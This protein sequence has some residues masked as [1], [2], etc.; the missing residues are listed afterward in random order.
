[1][2]DDSAEEAL[3]RS[4]T[5]GLTRQKV[6]LAAAFAGLVPE[7]APL[8]ALAL[9]GQRRRFRRPAPGASAPSA[10]LFPD[11]RPIV[12]E[13]ARR[14]L[15]S[16]LAG[17]GGDPSDVIAE[18]IA[19][20]IAQAG[21]RLHPFDLP[22]LDRFVAAEAERLGGSA[23]AWTERKG[24]EADEG[25]GNSPFI[26]TVDESN[27]TQ[28]RPAQKAR[29][30]R[31]VRAR[32]PGRARMLVESIFAG[33]L[34]PSRLGL[35]NALRDRLSAADAPFFESV[36]KDRAATVRDAAAALLARLPNA[37]ASA[38]RLHECLSRIERGKTGLIRRRVTLRLTFPATIVNADQRKVWLC[39]KFPGLTLDDLAGGLGLGV[40]EMIEAASEDAALTMLLAAFATTGRR[41]DILRRLVDRG[42][43]DAWEWIAW[44]EG[45]APADP[46]A[47]IEAALRPA[48]WTALPTISF[49]F[50][51]LYKRMRM[52]LPVSI[53]K[54]ILTCP[55]WQRYAAS[56]GEK[57]PDRAEEVI[58]GLTVL[59][60][61]AARPLL[62]QAFASLPPSLTAR[63]TA[64]MTVLDLIQSNQ[65]T[66]A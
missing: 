52:P 20:A 58:S 38:T 25:K 6:P 29:F 16:L 28:A 44:T 37:Q 36:A 12:P 57:V 30:I 41:Y 66:V 8:A 26:E 9:L 35:I 54:G 39:S 60:P 49:T 42:A 63:A 59:T 34:A 40:E 48:A 55:A 32:D 23:I 56:F 31:E 2:L 18:A 33:E 5:L 51:I 50:A 47:W 64:A 46:V 45:F 10:P 14:L 62:R 3:T 27:W 43:V 21:L 22:A 13:P 17:K 61:A 7:D 15:V 19:D 11:S 1:M 53:A 4:F 24:Q 65:E